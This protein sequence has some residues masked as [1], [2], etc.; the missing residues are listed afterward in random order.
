MSTKTTFK[1]I[2]LVA[3]AA[4][5]LGMLSVVPSSAS[6]GTP[7]VTLGNGTSTTALNYDSLTAGT[8]AISARMDTG[9]SITVGVVTKSIPSGAAANVGQLR[10]LDS[11]SA[12]NTFTGVFS[13]ITGGTQVSKLD[14]ATPSATP[15]FFITSGASGF[16]GANFRVELDSVTARTVGTYTYTVTVKTYNVGTALAAPITTTDYD[17]SIVV[18][19]VASASLVASALYSTLGEP[20]VAT[21]VATVSSTN[22]AAAT[23]L[24]TLKNAS[25]STAARESVTATITGPGTI[26]VSGS[27]IGK[28]V[29]LAYSSTSLTLSVFADGTAGVSTINVSTPSVTFSSKTV[30]FFAKAATKITASVITPVLGLGPNDNAISATAVDTNGTAWTGAMYIVASAAADALIGGSATAPI[31]CTY[32]T[33][34]LVHYCPVSTIAG[35][36]ANFKLIDATTVALAT[37]TSNEV[38]VRV[39]TAVAA[40]V[41]ISFDKATYLPNEKATISITPVDAAGKNVSAQASLA[42]LATGGISSTYAFGAASD[43]LTATTFATSY[44]TGTKSYTVYMPSA[45]VDVKITATG[46]STLPSAGQVAISASATV[47]DTTVVA[48][49]AAAADAAAEATDAANAATDASNAAAEAADAATAAAEDAADAA[50]AATEA[51]QAASDAVAALA[52]Q[53]ATLVAG[54]KAQLTALTNLIIKIQK[55]VAKLRK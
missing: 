10:Y 24:V 2:A 48:A 54:L 8:F 42:F 31:G 23:L 51:A 40:A 13:L 27:S 36:T 53:V 19:A 3:V 5:G 47:V 32:N 4:L 29:V 6:V 35:G 15:G 41:K 16:V 45:S 26:G 55:S 46:G 39:S 30:T 7:T 33:T 14:T 37:A 17:V 1:R 28:S 43:T 21:K 18:S 52:T 22:A 9:D 11:T 49:I 12:A 34:D 25:E 38:S 44:L 20:S 50:N